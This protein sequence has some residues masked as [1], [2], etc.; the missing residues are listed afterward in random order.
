LYSHRFKESREK[1]VE[2]SEV[3]YE[4]MMSLLRYMYSDE[5]EI[6][7]NQISELLYLADRYSVPSLKA[8]CEVEFAS[9]L[10][11]DNAALL[12]KYGKTYKCDRLSEVTLYF[13]EENF[14]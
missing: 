5:V 8:R 10:S 1:V 14:S 6:Q 2:I 12:Y 4:S 11:I 9:S 3:S 7:F 13:I